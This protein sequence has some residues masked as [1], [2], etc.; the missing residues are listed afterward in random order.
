MVVIVIAFDLYLL[1][2][3]VHAFDLAIGPRMIW[4]CK[5]MLNA[6]THACSIERMASPSCGWSISVFWQISELNA[7]IGQDGVNTVRH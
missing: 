1:D 6:V 7:V 5:P 3:P 2:R 4:L